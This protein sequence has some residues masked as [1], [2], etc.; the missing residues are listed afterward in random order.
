M[1]KTTLQTVFKFN[2][3]SICLL[4]AWSHVVQGSDLR[5]GLDVDLVGLDLHVTTAWRRKTKVA[6]RAQ[7]G[8]LII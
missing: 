2:L 7:W 3:V 5:L 8:K 1:K 6:V 4:A